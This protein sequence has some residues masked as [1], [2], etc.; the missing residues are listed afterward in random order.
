MTRFD[1][2]G[3]GNALVDMEYSVDDGF[4]HLHQVDKGH[5]TLVEETRID[6]LLSHLQDLE[7]TRTSGG[8]AANSLIAA[9]AFG[10]RTFY[11]CKVAADDTGRYFLDDLRRIGVSTNPHPREVD[12]KSGRCLVLITPDAER[13]MSTFLGISSQLGATE[14]NVEALRQSRYLYIEGFLSSSPAACAAALQCREIAASAGV[15]TVMTLSDAS[16]VAY[17]RDALTTLLGNGVEH[18]FCNEEEALD[19]ARTDRLDVAVNELKDV[20]RSVNVTLGAR[21]S[22]VANGR[23]RK[24]VPGFPVTPVDT[25]GAGDIYAGACLAAWASGIPADVAARFGNF[26]AAHLVTRYGARLATVDD[27]RSLLRRFRSVAH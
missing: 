13:S 25:N 18:L 19:W 26:A 14:I 20:A 3:L 4:L 16:M 2:Y 10:A 23:R 5:M 7:P 8:S 15:R 27:Y 17:F 6:L 21:G 9:Q 22:L 1:V 12:G 24:E 11:S